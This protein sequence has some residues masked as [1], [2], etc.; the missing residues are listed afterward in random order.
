M[1]IKTLRTKIRTLVSVYGKLTSLIRTT[2]TTPI[3]SCGLYKIDSLLYIILTSTILLNMNVE[4]KK[5]FVKNVEDLLQIFNNQKHNLV[6]FL[7]K[8]FKENIHY[9]L[10]KNSK[11]QHGGHNKVNYLLTENC[12]ELFKNSF[13]LRNRYITDINDN[14]QCVNIIMSLETSTIGFIAN[15]FCDILDV[16]QQQKIDKYKVD[17]YF[18]EY[19]LAIECDENNH[20]D[21][22]VVYEKTREDYILSLGNTIIRFNPND[23]KFDLSLVLREINKIILKKEVKSNLINVKF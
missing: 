3:C 8:N 7:K 19:N 18:P 17:L 21:R 15:S 13:N 14:I 16:N 12:F 22:D 1:I 4:T 10:D 2:T 5:L 23:K 9:I 20:D 6:I 11:K